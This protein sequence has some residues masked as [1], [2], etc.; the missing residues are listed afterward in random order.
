MSRAVMAVL[1]AALFGL[2]AGCNGGAVQ[3]AQPDAAAARPAG[4][5]DASD[6]EAEAEE[7]PV[8]PAA[9][10][11]PPTVDAQPPAK[12]GHRQSA[13]DFP[14]ITMVTHEG[15]QVDFYEDLVKDKIVVINF[16]YATCTGT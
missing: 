7:V 14:A 8:D 11:D 10:Y 4:N 5:V 1:A 16:M 6:E 13:P 12:V 15:E 9:L 2:G 3:A